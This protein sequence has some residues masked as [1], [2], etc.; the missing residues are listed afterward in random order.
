M[1]LLTFGAAIPLLLAFG[2][3]LEI[4]GC[5]AV[6]TSSRSGIGHGDSRSVEFCVYKCMRKRREEKRRNGRSKLYKL[7]SCINACLAH[8]GGES[9]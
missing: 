6:G 7:Y 2:T 9:K 3:R 4:C 1:G 5:R 8:V